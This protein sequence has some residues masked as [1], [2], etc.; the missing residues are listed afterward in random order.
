MVQSQKATAAQQIK[1]KAQQERE[2]LEE[3]IR[4]AKITLASQL[5][6]SVSEKIKNAM[7]VSERM[8]NTNH[9]IETAMKILD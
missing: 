7:A 1:E 6:D 9:A 8:E 3:K 2:I 5:T 4:N